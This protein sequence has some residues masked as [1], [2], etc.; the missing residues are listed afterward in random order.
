MKNT[1]YFYAVRISIL[2]AIFSESFIQIG[3]FLRLRVM[4]ENKS[5]CFL[6]NTLYNYSGGGYYQ[7]KSVRSY[8]KQCQK[9]VNFVRTFHIC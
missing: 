4:Q 8:I 3:Y 1:N 9:S 7:D 5:G 2:L 6:L